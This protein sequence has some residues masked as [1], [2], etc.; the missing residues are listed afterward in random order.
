[1]MNFEPN[2]GR[3]ADLLA[4]IDKAVADGVDVTPDT[5]PYLPG[6]TTLAAMLPSWAA[7]GGPDAQLAR[8]RDPASRERIATSW[9]TSARTAAT[10]A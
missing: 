1:M 10:A 2:R 9:S 3:G 5:Y 6:A 4:L 8:L 7:E